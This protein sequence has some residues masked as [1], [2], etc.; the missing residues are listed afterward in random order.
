MRK[1]KKKQIQH[2]IKLQY[3][4][5]KQVFM[6]NNQ[7]HSLF[8]RGSALWLGNLD[9]ANVSVASVQTPARLMFSPYDMN[10]SGE[11]AQNL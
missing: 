11:I 3:V 5:L 6:L 8:P 10:L 4:K 2:V 9:R 7:V 1:R